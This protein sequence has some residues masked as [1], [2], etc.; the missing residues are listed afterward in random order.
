V[1]KFLPT[2]SSVLGA[3]AMNHHGTKA[4]PQ[5]VLS[6]PFCAALGYSEEAVLND[7]RYLQAP[8]I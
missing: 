4:V 8:R 1:H 7:S 6:K 2:P 3:I 5:Q